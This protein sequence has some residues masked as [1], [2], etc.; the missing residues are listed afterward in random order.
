MKSLT[1]L[2]STGS[3]GRNVLHIAGEFP[4]RFRV[5][6]LCANRSVELLSQQILRFQPDIAV[7]GTKESALALERLLAGRISVDILH[8]SPGLA[9]AASLDSVDMVVAAMVGA[10]GLRPVVQAIQARKNIALANKETLVAAGSLVMELADTAGVS[11]LPID[12]EHSAVF[13]CL[14]GNHWKDIIKIILTCSGGPFR[15]VPARELE[16]LRPEQALRHPNWSMGEKITID[17]ATLM[18]KG[19]EIIEAAHLFRMPPERIEVLVHP[20]SIIH[21]MVAFRDGSILAQMGVPDMKTAISYALS[22]PER[23]PIG[24]P[25]PDF[26]KLGSFTFENPDMDRFPCLRLALEA[27]RT[28]G[29]LP[30]VMNAANEIAVQAFL[31]GR[32]PFTGIPAHIE[33]VMDHHAIVTS[34]SLEDILLADEWARRHITP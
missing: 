13:Q 34:P 24:Q 6:A 3:I 7:V 9:E 17:S 10:A 28:G 11:I 2:G 12:S 19:L 32:I 26:V 22:H 1:I 20:Q 30:A 21:S 8:G 29:T 16:S 5:R 4:D 14:Q 27:C 15:T 25:F 31:Q 18:N 23:L 33:R